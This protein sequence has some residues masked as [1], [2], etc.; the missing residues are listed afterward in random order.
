MQF[1]V[2]RIRDRLFS[3]RD[4][5]SRLLGASLLA[6]AMSAPALAQQAPVVVSVPAGALSTALN[7]L[8]VQTGVQIGFDSKILR[9][10][11]TAGLS[12]TYTAEAALAQLLAGTGVGFDFTDGK[13]VRIVERGVDA[14]PTSGPHDATELQAIV[15]QGSG[16]VI[17]ADGYVG[18]SSATGTKTDTPLQETP[19][20]MSTVTEAQIKD[21]NPQSLTD[22]IAYTPGARTDA[23]GTDPRYDSF[24][25]RGFNV[26]NTG[27]FRDNLRQPVAGYGY[28]LTEPYGIEGISVLRGPSS[29]LYGATG[30]GGLYNVISKRPTEETLREV[31]TQIGT[32]SRYQGQFD[33][34]GPVADNDAL[35]YR[36]TG[37]VRSA[38]TDFDYV[39]DDVSF[40]APA[41]TWKPDEDTK[42]TLLGEYSRSKTGGNPAYY[43]DVVGHVSQWEAGDP[44][45]NE[46]DHSMG[47]FGWE[48]EHAFSENLKF[49]QNARWSTQDISS[50]YAYAYSGTAH[51]ADPTLIDRGIGR[52]EQRLNAFVIDNQLEATFDTGQFEHT[53]VGGVDFTWVD[54]TSS[55]GGASIDPLDT[56]NPNYGAPIATPPLTARTDQRQLQTGIYIQDQLRYDAMTLT[57]GGRY[58]WVSTDTDSTDLTS[59]TTSS[60]KQEDGEFSGRI[61]VTYETPWSIVPYASYSTAFSPNVGWNS[62]TGAPFDPTTSTQKE[63]GVKYLVPDANMV[64]TAALFDIEQDNGLFYEV[65]SGVNTQVQRGRLRSRGMEIEAIASLDNGVSLAGSY[66]YTNLKILEGSSDTVGNYVSSVPMNMASLWVKYEMPENTAFSGLS[67]GAGARY[68]GKSYGND[69]NT[70]TNN[71]RVLFDASLSFD[72]AAL[73]PRYKGLTLQVNAKNLFDRRDTTCTGNY[74]YLDPGR[75]VIGSL[76]YTW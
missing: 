72:F 6:M 35:L 52:E 34:S 49:R 57:F 61:G 41:L 27:V 39:D 68:Q 10:K 55:S 37:V 70:L 12:G 11:T 19:Q 45:F 64:V 4:F 2:S 1:S 20:S 66:T 76:R 43:N 44:S 47:R 8:A 60:L 67:V 56:T 59:G 40:I 28:F 53:V 51:A 31:E 24:F 71:A 16:G 48:F 17:T 18:L 54:Y 32:D 26:T 14:E 23:Y 13:T 33:F 25:V 69:Q 9:G 30:A 58:D 36:L 5:H 65:I 42:L 29:A 75:T 63:I 7:Q 73:D 3:S 62:T 38:G 15:L 21:R 22:A 50:K 74:C 46:L